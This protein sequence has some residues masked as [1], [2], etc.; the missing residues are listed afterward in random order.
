MSMNECHS[1][2][3]ILSRL[4]VDRVKHCRP[5]KESIKKTSP[6]SMLPTELLIEIFTHVF[7]ESCDESS[8]EC[9]PPGLSAPTYATAFDPHSPSLFPYNAASVCS[10]W[11]DVI[12]SSSFPSFWTRI[13]VVVGITMPEL[14]QEMLSWSG[15]LIIGIAVIQDSSP[16]SAQAEVEDITRGV[17]PHIKRLEGLRYSLSRS[18]DLAVARKTLRGKARRLVYF[19]MGYEEDDGDGDRGQEQEVLFDASGEEVGKG[20]K[21]I[22]HVVQCL[23]VDNYSFKPA[24]YPKSDGFHDLLRLRSLSLSWPR[25]RDEQSSVG[26]VTGDKRA[27]RIHFREFLAVLQE[28]F[29]LLRLTVRNEQFDGLDESSLMTCYLP[30]LQ[31]VTLDCVSKVFRDRFRLAIDADPHSFVVTHLLDFPAKQTN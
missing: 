12:C 1:A 2:A 7:W 26:C 22:T 19:H 9:E 27:G 4:L 10:R 6:I 25:P 21:L 30:L 3:A 28:T 5:R 18:S 13:V 29:M 20:W 24:C 16:F 8:R 11:K 31:S 23:S 15:N 14:I 17:V